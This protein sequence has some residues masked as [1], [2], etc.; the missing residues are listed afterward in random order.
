M[1]A[2]QFQG[3]IEVSET[4]VLPP[5][6]KKLKGERLNFTQKWLEGDIKSWITAPAKS[7]FSMDGMDDV[8]G[9]MYPNFSK[10]FAY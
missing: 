1:L 9:L 3:D 10:F 7:D 6:Q 5:V 8:S 4:I 2:E